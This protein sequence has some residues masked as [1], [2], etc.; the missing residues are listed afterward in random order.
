MTAA[1]LIAVSLLAAPQLPAK[2]RVPAL[3][4]QRQAP[5]MALDLVVTGPKESQPGDLVVLSAENSQGAS[6][7]TWAVSPMSAVGRMLAVEGGAKVVFAT[8]TPG[9][10]VFFLAGCTADG[11]TIRWVA[12]EVQVG[13]VVPPGPQPVPPPG[14]GPAPVPPGPTPPPDRFGLAAFVLKQAA[15]VADA[16]KLANA[17]KMA[18]A[19][20]VVISQIGAG[21]LKTDKEIAAAFQEQLGDVPMMVKLRWR[22]ALYAL[23]DKF[24]SLK[25]TAPADWMQAF[26]EVA[27]GL[28]QVR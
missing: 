16:D 25:I 19:C 23:A 21:V 13:G 11:K 15:G 20:D 6:A 9:R 2:A 26:T 5:K 12:H 28:R 8:A 22:T 17:Q 4:A 3:I 27:A 14:P 10:Y 1:L 18:T 7:T 24:D